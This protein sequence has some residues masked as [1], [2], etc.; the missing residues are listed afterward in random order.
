MLP[1][2][3]LAIAV[4]PL[5]WGDL[6][7]GLRVRV[8]KTEFARRVTLARDAMA[9][10]EREGEWDALV[11]YALQSRSFTNLPPIEPAVSARRFVDSMEPAHRSCY[12]SGRCP[13]AGAVPADAA[14]RLEALRHSENPGRALYFRELLKTCDASAEY[15]RAMR[16]LYRKEFAGDQASYR[17]RGLSSD[18]SLAPNYT[19]WNA[20]TV[21]HAVDPK[22]RVRQALIV[23]PGL[24]IA[25][26]T[27]LTEHVEPQSYQPYLT[28]TALRQLGM[29][30]TVEVDC[31]DVNPLVVDFINNFSR[32]STLEFPRGGTAAAERDFLDWRKGLG[33]RLAVPRAVAEH[34]HAAKANLL[35][36]RSEAT[37]DLVVIT[38]VLVYFSDRELELAMGSIASMLRPDGYLIHNELRPELESISSAADLTAFAGRS[39]RIAPGLLDAFAIYKKGPI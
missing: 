14:N 33:D 27:G 13:A 2:L 11:Y 26:R 36:E 24:D 31:L 6:P 39:L 12:L 37:Y 7:E 9:R 21:L 8:P 10:R 16:F 38:N 19:V 30:E 32:K 4:R 3:L 34:V 1:L 15:R 23:G 28:A 25:S 22:F 20:L 17:T 5:A 29:A 35:A 18:T